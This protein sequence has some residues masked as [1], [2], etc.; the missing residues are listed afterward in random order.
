MNRTEIKH[1]L[2]RLSEAAD[3]ICDAHYVIDELDEEN[4]Q[5]K[6]RIQNLEIEIN[7]K[8]NV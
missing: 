8:E 1:M 3:A 6:N 4:D 7:N 2:K 5:L